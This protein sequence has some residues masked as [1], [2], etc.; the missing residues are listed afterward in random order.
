[1]GNTREGTVAARTAAARGTGAVAGLGA[2]AVAAAASAAAA[3][4]AVGP[5][6]HEPTNPLCRGA[7]KELVGMRYC[8]RRRERRRRTS[9]REMRKI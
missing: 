3:T 6:G 5:M 7:Q 8:G 2:D 9:R 4:G 1:M